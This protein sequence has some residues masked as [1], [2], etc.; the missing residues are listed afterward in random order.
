VGEDVGAVGLD[1][2]AGDEERAEAA[3]A[4]FGGDVDGGDPALVGVEAGHLDEDEAAEGG[5]AEARG[6]GGVGEL[7]GVV[8]D[9]VGH[10][11]GLDAEGRPCGA[12]CSG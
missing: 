5:G 10:G 1:A 4:G 12:S 9:A 3:A 8:A 6:G 11:D 7:E 2:A